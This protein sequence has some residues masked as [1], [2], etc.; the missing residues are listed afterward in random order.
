[1]RRI[2]DTWRK[3]LWNRVEL[4]FHETGKL[5]SEQKEITGVSI[6][7]FKD[8]TWISTSSLCEKACQISNVKTYVFSDSV[9][10]VEKREM[11]L[12]RPGRAKLNGIRKTITSKI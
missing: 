2:Y 12:C 3:N 1:M 11:I 9:L 6:V 7:G 4:L 10:F 8:A 5:I